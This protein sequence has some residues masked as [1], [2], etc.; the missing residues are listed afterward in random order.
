MV[1]DIMDDIEDVIQKNRRFLDD[2]VMEIRVLDGL[3]EIETFMG[4][5]ASVVYSVLY[6][7]AYDLRAETDFTGK[8]VWTFNGLVNSIEW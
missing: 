8:I 4:V 5:R 6:N 3:I 7:L 1:N 2:C